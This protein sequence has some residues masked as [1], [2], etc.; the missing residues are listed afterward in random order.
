MN[1]DLIDP[2][3]LRALV[4]VAE[5]GSFRAAARSLGYTQSAVSHQ[6]AAIERRLGVSV[7]VRPG[8]RGKVALT[9]YGEIVYQHAQRVIAANQALDAD[10]RAAL[11]GDRGTLR[12]S[13]SQTTCAVLVEPLAHL[14]R[15][16]PGIEVSLSNSATAETLAQ[17]LHHGQVDI[18]LYVNIQPDDRVVTS[19]LFEDNWMV[20]A[21]RDNPIAA[22]S[23]I[24]LD[25]L[26]GTEMIAWHQRWKAQANLERLWRQRGIRPRII[27]RTDDNMMIQRLVGNDLGCACLG[28]LAVGDL[29]DPSVRRLAIRDEVPPRSL[30]LCWA[31]DRA[32]P[33][34]AVLLRDAIRHLAAQRSFPDL[35]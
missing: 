33:P 3:T 4:T 34:A 25:A 27:Y 8:G 17:Q 16:S 29:I 19:P 5:T 20:I 31:R 13:I 18:G 26:D 12:I 22:S 28:A 15:T 10:V 11:A 23:S 24:T 21:H 6:I 9:A 7:F 1:V 35:P 2:R 32:L 30:S 14:R